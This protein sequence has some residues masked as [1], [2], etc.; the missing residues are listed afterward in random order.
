MDIVYRFVRDLVKT[1][2][3]NIQYKESENQ[4]ADIFTKALNY[5]L[6]KKHREDLG[7][8]EIK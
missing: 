8:C 6:F 7:M 1:K 5:E 3:V 4:T 2:I